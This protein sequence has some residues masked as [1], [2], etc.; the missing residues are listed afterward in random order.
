MWRTTLVASLVPLFLGTA[1]LGSSSFSFPSS[2][3]SVLP[4]SG[5]SAALG[6]ASDSQ[7]QNGL[8]SSHELIEF[9][10]EANWDELDDDRE[11]ESEERPGRVLLSGPGGEEHAIPIQLRTRGIF[12][13]K[14]STCTFPPFRLNFPS[15]GTE[16]T[17]FQGQDKIKL[18]DH[19]RD[20]DNFEQNVLEE[21]LAY[22][23]YN[24][25]TDIS[26]R[27]RL[28]RITYLDSRGEDDPV[29]RMAFLIEDEDSMAARVEGRMFEVQQA[30]ANQ[31]HQEQ[32]GLM[33]IFQFM[34]GNT[35]WSMTRFHNV[36]VMGIGREYF[37]IPYD[38]DF[39]GLVDAPYAG[40]GE[41]VF[42]RIDNV[43]E[44][45]YWGICNPSINYQA[46]FAR[47]NDKRGEILGIPATIPAL[48]ER[49]QRT[50]VRYLEDFYEII[51]NERRARRE[52]IS[53]CR[54]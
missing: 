29:T 44:R 34:I 30:P 43:R 6:P 16:G 35:D 41:L 14:K 3:S 52:I 31:F 51:D 24:V 50:A 13:L 48:T 8:F 37:P 45:L 40:P 4:G 39:S 19:C 46:L 27:V 32:A 38:F 54:G 49:N 20:R 15:E 1:T 22:R 28:A 33:Y 7:T 25:L 9:S 12:R 11:Q 2:P 18:V 26:F 53:V 21:Y 23:I 36:K 42:E 10:L 47:F 17:V 5:P